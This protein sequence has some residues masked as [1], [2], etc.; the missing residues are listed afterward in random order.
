[1]RVPLSWLTEFVTW[2]GSPAALAER[3]TMAGLEVSALEEVGNL[4]QRIVVG[5]LEAASAHPSAAN[6]HCWRVDVGAGAVVTLVSG[7]PGLV[8][9]RRVPVV[10]AD[11]VLPGGRRVDAVEIRGVRSDGMLCSEAE[12][13]LGDEADTIL[14]LPEDAAAGTV[15]RELPG[16]ADT[17]LELEVTPNRGDCLSIFGVAR[18]IAALTGT[19]LRQPRLRLQEAG[20]PA[21][22]QIAVQ[23]EAPDLCPRYSARI[24]RGVQVGPSPLWLR[25]RLRRAGMRPQTNV[26]D[27]SNYIM[28]ER[29]QPLHAFDLEQIAEGRIVVRRAAPGERLVTLD[30]TAR[31]LEADDLV[32]ADGQRP[33]ALAG[34]MGGKDSEVRP[35]TRALLLESAFFAPATV[36][37]TARRTG[38][39]SQAA[40]RFERRVDPAGVRPALDALAALIAKLAGGRIAPDVVEDVSPEHEPAIPPIRLRPRR[41]AS[42]LGM[43]TSR[44][45]ITRR[46]RALGARCGPAGEGLVVT[47]PSFR[48]DLRLEE[49]LIEEVARVGGYESIP[50][51]LPA[52]RLSAGSESDARALARRV[53]RV[54]VG[55]G[56]TEMVTL[57]FTDADMNQRMPGFVGR[58]LVP[59]GVRNPLSSELGE[60]RRSP[61]AGLV[62]ALRSNRA[63]QAAFVGAF[64]VGKGY[65]MEAT[66]AAQEPRA[67]AILLAGSWPARGVERQGPPVDFLDLKGVCENLFA[68]LGIEGRRVRWRPAGE[69]TF[70]HPAQAALIEVDGGTLGVAGALHPQISQGCDLAEEVWIAELD[71]A[72]LA[73]YVSRRVTLRP[74]PRFP[75]VTRDIAVVVDEAFRAGEIL[76]EVRAL[77]EPQVESVRL[78]DC[79][80]GS[81]VPPGKKSLAYTIA[82][83]AADR[84]L[85]DDEVN[86]LHA[87]VRE[88]LASRFRLEFRA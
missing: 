38:L 15:L 16:V 42:V 40:Y 19:R 76:E 14:T 70:L 72:E 26:V 74:L 63:Q 2:N 67:I 35:E 44:G 10:L 88:R 9:G 49:D 1:M 53:R 78:F 32:I 34:V 20:A 27:A 51:T 66:G 11:A 83:R 4:D 47:P 7:A 56:L 25:L 13:G 58:A 81:P 36:R 68:G 21:A 30:G 28:L 48:G 22:S 77:E 8:P 41:V 3:L 65:G 79:Y 24:V 62:R 84:T 61:L 54:L 64:E 31:T 17:V 46:L 52:V 60:L 71:F 73:H 86:A 82:Y 50:M 87:A 5:R 85:T 75:A 57:A 43:P 23:V 55:E 18:E 6:L 59:L 45:E 80:R 12:L 29:G 39:V 37:R 33:V 69:V